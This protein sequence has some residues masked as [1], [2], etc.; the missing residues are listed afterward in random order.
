MYWGGDWL[1]GLPVIVLT[2]TLHICVFVF[3]ERMLARSLKTRERHAAY[4]I[5]SITLV[6]LIAI[7]LHAFEALIWAV[8]FVFVKA[9]PDPRDAVLYS[10][11]S[12]TA[13]GHAP[14]F[15]DKRWQL[16][17]AMEAMNGVILFGLTTAFLFAA[18][19]L[20]RPDRND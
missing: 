18:V 9:L 1:W 10:L 20:A 13:F 5:A 19:Q 14:L 3:V 16:L 6:A 12:I 17:G 11:S 15:L 2:I 7:A 4:R 8:L